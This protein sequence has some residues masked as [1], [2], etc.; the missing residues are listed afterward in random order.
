ML[1]MFAM[2]NRNAPRPERFTAIFFKSNW[3]IVGNNVIAALKFYFENEYMYFPQN[4]ASLSL[5]PKIKDAVQMK[6]FRPI[7]CYNLL[8]KWHSDVLAYIRLKKVLPDL[9]SKTQNAFIKGR[10]IA[11]SV[12]IMHELVRE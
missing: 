12:L 5:I 2:K 6:D 11:D 7:S 1:T 9:I 4:N 10:Q 8:R 3:E